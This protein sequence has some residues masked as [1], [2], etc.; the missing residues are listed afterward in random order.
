M[1]A[2]L[3]KYGTTGVSN[4][5]IQ[6]KFHR[7]AKE[8]FQLAVKNDYDYI[9]S[10]KESIRFFALDLPAEIKE[11]F[12]P[13]SNAPIFWIYESSLLNQIEEFMKFN[14]IKDSHIEIHKSIKENYTKWVTTKLKSEKEYFS[15]ITVNFIERDINKHNFFKMILKAIIHTYQNTFFNPV[16]ALELL[17][18]AI[19]L[20]NSNKLNDS[21][22]GE[23]RYICNL[24]IGYIH[25]KE[26]G[27]EKANQAFKDALEFKSHGNT[28]RIYCA[29]T[30]LK[31]EREDSAVYYLRE[32][33]NYDIYRLS[34]AIKTNNLGMFSYFFRNA[35]FY[36]V[37]QEKDFYIAYSSIEQILEEYKFHNEDL[38]RKGKLKLELLKTKKFE[39]YY[40]DEIKKSLAFTEKLIQNY[41]G[42][43]NTV[44]YAIFPEIQR[45]F[46]N[47]L[48]S[49]NVKIRDKYV[50]QVM[51]KLASFEPVIKENVN[52]EKRL[53]DEVEKY[54][55]KSKDML[56]ESIQRTNENYDLDTRALEERINNLSNEDR[57]NPRASMSNNMTY[58]IIIAFVVFFIGGVAGYSDRMVSDLSEFNSIFTYVL[59]SGSKWGASSFVLGAFISAIIS[60]IIVMERYDVKQKIQRR[61]NYLKYE[62]EKVIADLKES[63][64]QKDKNMID[65]YNSSI[66]QYHKRIDELKAQRDEGERELMREAEENIKNLS[67]ELVKF[68]SAT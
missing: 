42:S 52:A 22:K 41:G 45:K 48:Q 46:D 32:V 35:F 3:E 8:H 5:M 65:N 37:F 17:T 13:Y 44:F 23:L 28:A 36:N 14:F 2:V 49:I 26:N 25:L 47:I 55:I 21:A 54:K 24:Y 30:E 40:D 12:I 27:Y 68:L 15:N 20:I 57:Y 67:E 50:S 56:A 9:N 60:G 34:L 18:N 29:L 59:I 64:A 58:N 51:E 31:L 62:R 7:L 38:L 1:A 66:Q 33:F 4:E 39:E 16:K 19:D 61:I 6:T 53:T 11:I 43:L 63:T 10:I